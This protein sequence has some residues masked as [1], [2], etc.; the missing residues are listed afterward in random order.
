MKKI[1]AIACMAWLFLAGA[2]ADNISAEDVQMQTGATKTVSISLTNTETNLVGFQ[3]DLTLPEGISINKAGCSLG[4]RIVDPDQVLT[5]GKQG[6]NVYR[7][8]STSLALTPIS[9]TSGALLTLS[10]TAAESAHSGKATLSDIVFVTNN[11]EEVTTDDTSFNI[12]L[13]YMQ[14]TLALET[15][16]TMTYGDANYTLPET[17]EEGLTLTWTSGNTD[18]ATVSG[19]TLTVAHAGTATITA[20]QEGN[21]DYVAFSREYTLTVEKAALTIT[22]N[23]CTKVGG[24]ENPELSVSYEG[25]VNGEDQSVLTQQPTVTTEATTD[26]PVGSYPITASGAEAENYDISYVAGTLTVIDGR[27]SAEDIILQ[28]GG[29]MTVDI[30]LTNSGNN[31]VS[32][33]M[34]L[35][36]PEGISIDKAGCSLSS[37]IGDT[38]QVLT[39]G[40]QG[41][42]VYRLTSTSFTLTPISGTS[43]A[44]L[45]LSLTAT[46]TAQCGTATLSGIVFA[47]NNSDELVLPDAS[48]N[49]KE[50]DE[51]TLALE[52][53]PSMTYGDDAYTLPE[54]TEEGLTLTWTSGNAVATISGNTLTVGNAGTATI[55]ATQEGNYFYKAFSREYTLTVGKATLTITAN[56]C[57]K[58]EGEENPELTVS[59][60]GFKY[61]DDASVLTQQPVVTTEATPDSPA[62]SYPITASGAEAANYDISY[63][64]G[65]LT[66]EEAPLEPTDISQMDNAIYVEKAQGGKGGSGTIVISLK[67]AQGAAAYQFNLKLPEGVTLKTNNEGEYTCTLSSRHRGHN[68]NI[69]VLED[70]GVYRIVVSSLQSKMID[71]NDGTVLTI[72]VDVSDD[73]EL[74]SYPIFIQNARYSLLG[75]TAVHMQETIGVFDVEDFLLG[76]VNNDGD[77]DVAD[78]VCIVNNSIGKPN[79]IFVEKAADVDYDGEIDIADAVKLVNFIIK[80]I[81]V[82]SHHGIGEATVNLPE[83]Q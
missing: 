35:T 53:L 7:L 69:N 67:N 58:V 13:S 28:P 18:I 52:E 20:T 34:D 16:P 12:T 47:T 71:G 8:T 23:D 74:G 46:E 21:D 44:L 82:L 1:I 50:K 51:Q 73:L 5:I 72:A 15:L 61:D 17:T 78:V 76:D 6:D 43:G 80:K 75:G 57:T 37:R 30:S 81:S 24:E 11:S 31:L 9:G 32:F 60:E 26:S 14:Q 66:V 36:L 38:D 54:T 45:T 40:K 83:P 2:W 64:A 42:N 33:Q 27:I 70:E 19:N 3:M 77:I 65:T 39:I 22:A 49:I 25:F 29:N 56:D 79:D 62:G 55:T 59:Y 4:S 68:A 10:L 63:V 48:F 41:D